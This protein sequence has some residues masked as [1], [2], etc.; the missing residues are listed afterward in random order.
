MYCSVERLKTP[1]LSVLLAIGNPLPLPAKIPE[2][3]Y[4]AVEVEQIAR[5]FGVEARVLQAQEATV[6]ATESGLEHSNYLHFACHGQYQTERP[7]A[8][9]LLLSGGDILTLAELFARQSNMK[10][11]RLVV[12][13]ACQSALT[14][15]VWLPEEAIGLP[16][17]FL[18]AG[19]LG[20]IGSL[21]S[22]S[23]LSTSLLMLKFYDLHLKSETPS[24]RGPLSPA[25][26]L[27]RAQVWL[28]DVTYGE[29]T[30]LFDRLR[31]DSPSPSMR[32]VA[33]EQFRI[34]ALRG[35]DE[36]PYAHP[37]YWA[38]FVFYGG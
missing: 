35:P 20:V 14:D 37:Y 15:Q 12:L 31:H 6:W 25:R 30:D 13:S 33:Q 5:L 2:L 7:L 28:R 26:A 17:G 1:R 18:Q 38:P 36:K 16:A 11:W 29:L 22:V 4:A 32:Q 24:D 23:D 27:Q 9:G 19:A 8:S 3:P 34:C 10:F 21:W